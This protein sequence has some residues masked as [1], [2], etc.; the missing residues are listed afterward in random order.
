M[1]IERWTGATA[2]PPVL[3]PDPGFD[4]TYGW[5]LDRL[6]T[7][8][9]PADEPS[10]LDA[11]WRDV[12]HEVH[13]V[14]PAP[15]LSVF[16]PLTDDVAP[17]AD[18]SAAEHDRYHHYEVA[19][20]TYRSLD[21]ARIGGWVLRPTSGASS[22]AV[23]G[24]GYGGRAEPSLGGV[25]EG[26]LAV[27]PV[28]RG[29]PTRSTVP[30][31]GGED[32]LHHAVW[33]IASPRS[34][35]HVGSVAD[36]MLAAT[37]GRDLGPSAA[38]LTYSGESFGGGIGALTLMVDDR[39]DD[40][41]LGVPSFGNNP[42]RATVESR[43]SAEAVRRHLLRHPEDLATIRYTDAASAARRIH[44][45]VFVRVA[46]ADPNV[47]PPGQFAVALSLA[48]P[49]WVHVS[50]AGHA[51]WPGEDPREAPSDTEVFDWLRHRSVPSG[52]PRSLGVVRARHS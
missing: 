51:S 14:D 18:A 39:F 9:A 20:L 24:H 42:W 19:D 3:D 47:P 5:D 50:P 38:R 37:I 43:G 45:P 6:R 32:G 33:G 22:V 35:S 29:L 7:A 27:Q 21:G 48:G 28:A 30:G 11:F 36:Y 13:A 10:D 4:A 31:I 15:Q 16:R 12:A 41:R 49:T 34:Y 26:A 23:V 1:S 8:S 25:P 17:P 44:V 2:A 40:A 52:R 46:L